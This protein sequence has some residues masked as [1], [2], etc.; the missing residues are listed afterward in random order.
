MCVTRSFN[1]TLRFINSHFNV[2]SISIH[3]NGSM[4]YCGSFLNAFS[5]LHITS[6]SLELKTMFAL[7]RHQIFNSSHYQM[8]EIK[9]N[10]HTHNITL[11]M[12]NFQSARPMCLRCCHVAHFD[13]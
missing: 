5:C 8:A 11:N 12:K 2:F 10:T 13:Q 6:E 9:T 7:G 3:R 4:S 1:I